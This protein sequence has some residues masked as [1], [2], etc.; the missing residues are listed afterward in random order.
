MD[1]RE[2][3]QRLAWN[4]VGDPDRYRP[5]GCGDAVPQQADGQLMTTVLMIGGLSLFAV[6]TG[7]ITSLFVTRAQAEQ[8]EA[9]DDLLVQ[10][11]D[12]ISADLNAMREELAH[13]AAGDSRGPPGG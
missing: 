5:F 7:T 10:Q 1:P 3:R 8:G 12:Q 6:I 11:M 2:L 13:I 9:R 4:V